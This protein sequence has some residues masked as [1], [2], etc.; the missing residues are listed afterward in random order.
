MAAKKKKAKLGW[1]GQIFLIFML[2][3]GVIFTPTTIILMVGMLPTIVAAFADVT[4]QKTRGITVG[5]MN[6]AG[7]MPFVIKL[8]TSEHITSRAIEL[9]SDMRVLIIMW[10]AA[11]IGYLIEWAVSGFVAAMM[12]ERG[13]KRL[14]DIAKEQEALIQRWGEEVTGEIPL[15]PDGFPLEEGG[16]MPEKKEPAHGVKSIFD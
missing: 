16:G 15:D 7:C 3:T 10:A 11:G 8:W 6:L 2:F 14:R 13:E 4:P 9:V 5:A 12:I 1:R